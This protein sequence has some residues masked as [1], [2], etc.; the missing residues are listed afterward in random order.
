MATVTH[1]PSL[2]LSVLKAACEGRVD[3][4]EVLVV[5]NSIVINAQLFK[6]HAPWLWFDD[7]DRKDVLPLLHAWGGTAL[8]SETAQTHFRF[9]TR[10]L[11]LS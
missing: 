2:L 1:H 11:D 6:G 7:P 8:S 10:K 9:W 3:E 4:V 5:T